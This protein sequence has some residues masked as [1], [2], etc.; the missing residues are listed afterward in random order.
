MHRTP[1]TASR[2]SFD[3]EPDADDDGLGTPERLRQEDDDLDDGDPEVGVAH[4]IKPLPLRE[5][6][7]EEL[8]EADIMEELEM[9]E[10]NAHDLAR[11]DGPDL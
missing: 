3:R 6:E 9:E 5:D 7:E 1:S 2:S 8:S 4:R 10:L 11:R